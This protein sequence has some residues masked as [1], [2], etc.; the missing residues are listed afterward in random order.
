MKKVKK[1]CYIFYRPNNLKYFTKFFR[2]DILHSCSY[3]LS[4]SLMKK[5]TTTDVFN[6]GERKSLTLINSGIIN[7][8]AD[9]LL[10][11]IGGVWRLVSLCMFLKYLKSL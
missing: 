9:W 10:S 6:E 7:L 1:N 4:F 5:V 3:C 11:I 8:L 2:I